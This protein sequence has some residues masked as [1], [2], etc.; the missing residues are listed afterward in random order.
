MKSTLRYAIVSTAFLVL[1]TLS[2]AQQFT[3][4]K[5]NNADVYYGP[6]Y[7][8]RE[9]LNLTEANGMLF[10]N[11]YGGYGSNGGLWRTD[12][13]DVGTV[14]IKD[15]FSIEKMLSVNGTLF[16]TTGG[17]LW[18]SDGSEVGTVLVKNVSAID[19]IN[20]NGTLFFTND[21]GLWKSDGTEGGTILLKALSGVQNITDVNGT[22]FFSSSGALWKSD[23]SEPGTVV[24][25]DNFN[26]YSYVT[27]FL[28]ANGILYFNV[29]YWGN[30][31]LELW[32][33]DG[34]D[35]GTKMI[36]DS[37]NGATI[38][39]ARNFT[40]LNG[41][42]Y[43]FASTST[44]GNA[45]WRTDGTDSGTFEVKEVNVSSYPEELFAFNGNL[46]FSASDSVHGLE[47]WKSD[48]TPVGTQMLKDIFPDYNGTYPNGSA[49]GGF[50]NL[51]GTL[52]F[53]AYGDYGNQLW[54]SDG[55]AAGTII[56]GGPC[57]EPSSLTNVNGVLFFVAFGLYGREIWKSNGTAVGT[58]M[59][60]DIFATGGSN[61]REFVLL[62]GVVYFAADPHIR[63]Y[64]FI[65][66]DQLFRTDGT[67]ANTFD[68]W[69]SPMFRTLP[70]N[71]TV[72]KGLV[73][74]SGS[75]EYGRGL[76]KSDGTSAGTVKVQT[77]NIITQNINQPGNHS[78]F[79]VV[80]QTMF[81]TATDANTGVELW[82]T[83]GTSEGT[84]RVKD[85]NPNGDSNPRNLTNVN[86][87]LYFVADDGSG[88]ALWRSD[89][90]DSG[91][92]IVKHYYAASSSSPAYLTEKQGIIYFTADDG[93]NGVELW[94]SDGTLEGTKMVKNIKSGLAGSNPSALINANGLL[95]FSA[96]DGVN[97]AELWKSDGTEGGTVMVR[98]IRSG[99]SGSFPASITNLNGIVYFSADDGTTGRELW[100][101]NGT[102]TGTVLVK[103][104]WPGDNG[105]NPGSL[106]KIGSNIL[107]AANNGVNGN[108]V[109]TIN[110]AT[111]DARMMSEIEPGP[112]SSDPRLF[113]EYESKVLV[114]A[115]NN[116]VGEEVW[117][118]DIPSDIPTGL[119]AVVTVNGPL[120]ICT[121]QTV[122]L[123]ANTGTD[124]TYQWKKAGVNITGATQS[125]YTATTAGYY[126]VVV[127]DGFGATAT[128]E[129]VIV[130]VVNPPLATVAAAGPLSF[131]A[132]KN[133][134]L[135]AI[136]G[137]G[138]TYQWKKSGIDI[139]NEISSNY[140]ATTAGT[141]SVVVTNATGCSATSQLMNVTVNPV[142]LATVAA[143]SAL[144]FCE[145]K[146]VQLKAITGTGYTYQWK[147]GALDIVGATS[148]T[149][150][151][152][153]TGIYT[154]IV[155]NAGGCSATSAG[156]NVVV[157]PLPAAT[158][159][160][161]GPT[162]FCSGQNVLL[163]ANTGT[164]YT[165]QW[166]RGATPIPGATQANYS[167]S[168]LGFY[169]VIA[170]NASGCSVTSAAIAVSVNPL[171]VAT[172]TPT[173]PLTF[174]SG[175][176]VLLRANTGT[177][178]TYQWK[179]AGINIAGAIQASYPAT[180]SGAYSVVVTN[181]SG[182]A[183]TSSAVTVTV[184]NAPL[185][186]VAVASS[187]TF[188]AGKSVLLK[189]IVGAGYTYQWKKNN[190]NIVGE[191]TSNYTA[192][193]AGNYS[194][195]VSN[196][197]GCSTSSSIIPVFTTPA[198][199][200]TVAV[201]GPLTFC[202]GGS[203]LLKG[204][205]GT[206]YTYQWKKNG[207]NIPAQTQSNFT[208]NTNG[209]YTVLVTNAQGCTAL[210]NNIN[211]TVI[212]APA[213]IITANGPLTFAQGGSVT[214]NVPA[215][216]GNNYQWR[217]D[218]V[219]ISGATTASY[220]ATTSGSYTVAVTNAGGCQAVSQASVVTVTQSRPITK[221]YVEEEDKITAY[222]NPLHRNNYLNIDWSIA[223][224]N[225]VFVTVYDM[226]GKKINS[227]RLLAGDRTIK[228]TGASGVYFV[229]CRWGI[230]KRKVFKVV[231]IE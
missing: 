15:V 217:K 128:S 185:A 13:T 70:Q 6:T 208:A 81:F 87:V 169:T 192:T 191:T 69:G 21:G 59:V 205:V 106:T 229:E 67:V 38:H 105:S 57:S 104:I 119:Q 176:N 53:T 109:W 159:T 96:D 117:I 72:F 213:T 27:N 163:K 50:F 170:T 195:V 184:N 134:L 77:I 127:T 30:G 19:L 136:I 155:T 133:V 200:A 32:K 203:V 131:C 145:G 150:N 125:I 16:F 214:L 157:K 165:Y 11:I 54:K 198:P 17:E 175:Q 12:G 98:N 68:L 122:Q 71:L 202:E 181:A 107:F 100:R 86:G 177:N 129:T 209:V 52:Y 34:T 82:K 47:L 101:S 66:R 210:S 88:F 25:K 29:V 37:D 189:A 151:A 193:T 164:N 158:I 160:A 220:A 7:Y 180:T 216:A 84:V 148:S 172:I 8:P 31:A 24:V 142:P 228:I 62:N 79:C 219:S 222:P 187:T 171:P 39:G 56:V 23:G 91:T 168:Q 41:I 215:V 60:K 130:T 115:T 154:V 89:G 80:N 74:F 14:R 75:D 188:C 224:D 225:A 9:P 3:L 153:V 18:K 166:I 35:T 92:V 147:R 196:S 139:Q 190:V 42:V 102:P 124:Y 197:S 45:L 144:T 227:Q 4:L 212:P 85:I 149:F 93:V 83:D 206:G 183:V 116:M 114:A 44:N 121:G 194:V 141:Y 230:N 152:S 138:Y 10:F 97:G 94:R 64:T 2:F 218:G 76:W 231:K 123:K 126:S 199:L 22:L 211:V 95:F 137:T 111:T 143:A 26:E 61:P 146:T 161:A 63:G 36:K 110:N 28:N 58:I 132:G 204:I 90:T 78:N 55:T 33:S 179:K 43:F 201:T 178:Y 20:V 46:F 99:N 173:G 108:E 135:K 65:L 112:G 49:P 1:G 120:S 162:T 103:D 167:A 73:F 113:F 5:D 226:S 174:C 223:G 48:G 207:A 118:A 51:N 40:F 182:C 140:T 221:G 156:L 186:T